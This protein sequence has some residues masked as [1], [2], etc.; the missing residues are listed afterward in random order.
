MVSDNPEAPEFTAL[1]PE[2]DWDVL[3]KGILI[4]GTYKILERVPRWVGRRRFRAQTMDSDEE[5][6]LIF[7]NPS[8]E[9][10]QE[11]ESLARI[12]APLGDP[13]L[14]GVLDL[15]R[16]LDYHFV[17]AQWSQGVVLADFLNENG[18]ASAE[19]A[20]ALVLALS[21]T[22]R[23][24]NLAELPTLSISPQSILI[25]REGSVWK[26]ILF[27]LPMQANN[28][29]PSAPE[30]HAA[31][32]RELLFTLCTGLEAPA[33]FKPRH[34]QLL[35]EPV[36]TLWSTLFHEAPNLDLLESVLG[37][38][39][40]A[41]LPHRTVPRPLPPAQ[42]AGRKKNAEGISVP[43]QTQRRTPMQS[44]PKTEA[45]P[46]TRFTMQSWETQPKRSL[47]NRSLWFNVFGA[48]IAALGLGFVAWLA[49][50]TVQTLRDEPAESEF[51]F[52]AETPPVPAPVAKPSG[53]PGGTT[54]AAHTPTPVPATPLDMALAM[55]VQYTKHPTNSTSE[56][57]LATALAA[58][59]DRADFIRAGNAPK[60]LKALE[61]ASAA[62]SPSASL[63]LAQVLWGRETDR[64]ERLFIHL[65][66][67]GDPFAIRFCEDQYIEWKEK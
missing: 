56:A 54:N 8:P 3:C 36:N 2:P 64:S 6:M 67:Q 14:L 32:L 30:S 17:V 13:H 26:P 57:Q 40:P 62:G 31:S 55:C 24:L 39:I 59:A 10:W 12:F 25:E 53:T 20:R 41:A 48:L 21:R 61:E 5:R 19:T 52:L 23:R 29:T 35:P 33:E 37:H 45:A 28:A 50:T 44:P 4:A 11:W 18:P 60:L 22:L 16:A 1:L 51:R 34:V 46:K 15:E 47:E 27:P 63:L 7:F 65:A 42:S 43:A 66:R 9:H 58:I 38:S 49:Y